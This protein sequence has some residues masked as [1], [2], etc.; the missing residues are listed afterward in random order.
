[1][2]RNC[3]SP[4]THVEPCNEVYVLKVK[5]VL[6]QGWGELGDT[7]FKKQYALLHTLRLYLNNFV[8]TAYELITLVFRI[9][10]SA[11]LMANMG[12]DL[13]VTRQ[14][15]TCL[16]SSKCRGKDNM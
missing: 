9:T 13:E 5:G 12:N 4:S 1:M 10:C 14:R 15:S 2:R 7:V 6:A 8:N 3:Q 16:L 11:P